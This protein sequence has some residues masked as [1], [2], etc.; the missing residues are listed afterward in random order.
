VPGATSRR[1]VLT[2]NK[3]ID[4][5]PEL[6]QYLAAMDDRIMEALRD[7]QTELTRKLSSFLAEAGV[8]RPRQP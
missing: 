6:R 1:S 2:T 3:E 4:G 5:D 7:M 8:D